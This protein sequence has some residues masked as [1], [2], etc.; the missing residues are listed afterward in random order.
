MLGTVL[1]LHT[2]L[3]YSYYLESVVL[4]LANPTSTL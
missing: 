4:G 3:G 1:Y 2:S